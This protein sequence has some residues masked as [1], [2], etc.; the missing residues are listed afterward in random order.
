MISSLDNA[1]NDPRSKNFALIQTILA[2]C[3]LVSIISIIL[4]TVQSL[5]SWQLYFTLIELVTTA[6]FTVEYL[7]RVISSPKKLGYILSLWGIT[8]LL[9]ILPTFLGFGNWT[10][11][12]AGRTLRILRLFRIIRIAKISRAY[13]QSNQKDKTESDFNSL[14]VGIYFLAL[15][16]AI[17]TFGSVL[18]LF[19][20]HQQAYEDIPQAML[21]AAKVLLGGLGVVPTQTWA[22]ELVILL[23]RFAGLALFGLLISVIGNS[24][25]DLLFHHE[26]KD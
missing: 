22:G 11:L 15:F 10:F 1:L 21:Q 24:L 9:A 25:K 20:G 23:A 19:E 3:T 17:I 4:E 2:V 7:T 12:K 8:D 6:V 26:I 13:L 5:S 14:T 18:Y 16:S